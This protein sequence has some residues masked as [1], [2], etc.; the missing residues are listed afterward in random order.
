MCPRRPRWPVMAFLSTCWPRC[1]KLCPW[2]SPTAS[3]AE[4]A[5]CLFPS[6]ASP[7][8]DKRWTWPPALALASL[9]REC[10]SY[11][12]FQGPCR[13]RSS[14]GNRPQTHI[15]SGMPEKE[16]GVSNAGAL[17]TVFDGQAM[18]CPLKGFSSE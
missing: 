5:L 7:C 1:S 3:G 16:S 6:W 2:A 11:I 18:T 14:G 9:W 12:F 15:F 13:I 10:W 4:S 17:L 8:S